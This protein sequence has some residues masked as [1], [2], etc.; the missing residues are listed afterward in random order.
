[1]DNGHPSQ[2]AMMMWCFRMMSQFVWKRQTNR[3][4][5]SNL[6]E[7]VDGETRAVRTLNSAGSAG[8]W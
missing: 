4:K 1:M 5:R 8:G 3:G 6:V 7:T 2:F